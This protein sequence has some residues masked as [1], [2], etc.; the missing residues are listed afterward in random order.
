MYLGYSYNMSY[1]IMNSINITDYSFDF[2]IKNTIISYNYYKTLISSD[3]EADYN[4]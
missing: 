4:G 2:F 1:I 3:H